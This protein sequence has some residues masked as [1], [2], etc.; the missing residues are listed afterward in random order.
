MSGPRRADDRWIGGGARPPE[1]AWTP[2]SARIAEDDRIAEDAWIAEDKARHL[3]ASLAITAVSFG[4]AT[5]LDV[6]WPDAGLAAGAVAGVAGLG[7][8]VRDYRR[9]RPFSVKDLAWDAAGIGAGLVLAS[10]AR[11]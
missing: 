3:F 11:R 5:A 10:A 6:E 4:L 2:E 1:N 7:K 8:E 9:G